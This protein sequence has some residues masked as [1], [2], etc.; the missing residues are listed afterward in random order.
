MEKLRR[1][2]PAC[3]TIDVGAVPGVNE[4]LSEADEVGCPVDGSGLACL[5][6]VNCSGSG[7]GCR[8]L[9]KVREK[10]RLEVGESGGS[11]GNAAVVAAVVVDAEEM[12]SS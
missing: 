10:N 9:G 5:P 6:G 2:C 3:W 11:G 8:R 4:K 12:L 7:W 1:P